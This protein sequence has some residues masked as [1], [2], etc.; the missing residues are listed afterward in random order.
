MLLPY[1]AH[2][3]WVDCTLLVNDKCVQ[4]LLFVLFGFMSIIQ[5]LFGINEIFPEC[6]QYKKKWRNIDLRIF[7]YSAKK[8]KIVF[9]SCVLCYK[10]ARDRSLK[11]C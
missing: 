9:T 1:H 4:V 8:K 2:T 10:Q 3:K 7:Q 6:S 5:S 11:L